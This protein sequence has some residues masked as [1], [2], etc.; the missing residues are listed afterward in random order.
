MLKKSVSVIGF[1]AA[2]SIACPAA[3][4]AAPAAPTSTQIVTAVSPLIGLT[5]GQ[6]N[7]VRKAKA[8][9]RFE[10]FSRS[11]LI[12]QLKF[13]GFSTKNATFAVDHISVSW[14]HQA[15]K[16]AKA[17]LK[18]EAFSL[19]GLIAQLEFDGFTHGQARYGAKKAF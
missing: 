1:L 8:Y 18:F 14:K 9:L 16:K 11:G 4:T 19:S 5:S 13:D 12:D 17:Y 2:V 7:A 3:A 6:A 10:A 15:Y